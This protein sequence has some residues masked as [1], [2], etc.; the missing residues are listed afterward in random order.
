MEWR[1]QQDAPHMTGDLR[2]S[3][4][5]EPFRREGTRYRA[6]I[7]A[8]APHAHLVEFGTGIYIGRGRI[9]PRRARALVFFWLRGPSGP[10]VYAYASV[11]GI[12]GQHYFHGPMPQRFT[13]SLDT[14][15]R[16]G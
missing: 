7:M 9:Y 2:R 8:T 4:V 3:I 14:F 15:F 11:A 1:T 6:K 10:Q 16:G 5:C 13:E 12:R